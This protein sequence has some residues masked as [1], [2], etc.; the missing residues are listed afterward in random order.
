[1][2]KCSPIIH[3]DSHEKLIFTLTNTMAKQLNKIKAILNIVVYFLEVCAARV[4]K[5]HAFN[6]LPLQSGFRNSIKFKYY[7]LINS[8]YLHYYR[9]FL[10]FLVYTFCIHYSAEPIYC[11]G[12]WDADGWDEFDKLQTPVS[13]N[14]LRNDTLYYITRIR[15]GIGHDALGNPARGWLYTIGHY[16]EGFVRGSMPFVHP[17]SNHDA[18]LSVFIHEHNVAK[19]LVASNGASSS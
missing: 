17:S 11:A 6:H 10:F 12:G 3:Q 7:S 5:P 8:R 15:S 13:R 2:F 19:A 14:I 4:P 16:K 9:I 1:M 18:A